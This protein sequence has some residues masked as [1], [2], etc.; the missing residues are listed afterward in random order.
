MGSTSSVRAD[1]D[2]MAS[3]KLTCGFVHP[4][5]LRLEDLMRYRSGSLTNA[6]QQL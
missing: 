4:A 6:I 1:D 2:G 5:I 3:G